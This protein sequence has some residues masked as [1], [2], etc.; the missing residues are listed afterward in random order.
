MLNRTSGMSLERSSR[1][2]GVVRS[3]S[4]N[5]RP[6]VV[7]NAVT[8]AEGDAIQPD[9]QPAAPAVAT[10]EELKEFE[11]WRRLA[12]AR[13]SWWWGHEAIHPSLDKIF[14]TGLVAAAATPAVLLLPT[15]APLV[16]VESAFSYFD[17]AVDDWPLWTLRASIALAAHPAITLTCATSCALAFASQRS[18]LNSVGWVENSSA[19]VKEATRIG[20]IVGLT[21]ALVSPL[22][23]LA[24]HHGLTLGWLDGLMPRALAIDYWG[25][26]GGFATFSY[27][28]VLY[29]ASL[30]VTTWCGAR[31]GP[32]CARM[33]YANDGGESFRA[34]LKYAGGALALVTILSLYMHRQWEFSF[35]QQ[36]EV[37]GALND[38]TD[39]AG[40]DREPWLNEKHRAWEF[41]VAA[42]SKVPGVSAVVSSHGSS[43][44]S[45]MAERPEGEFVPSASFS[46]KRS[47]YVYK[48]GPQGT[49]YY[50]DCYAPP[51]QTRIRNESA[52]A[53][54]KA[55]E[56]ID[57]LVQSALRASRRSA[58]LS[59][60]LRQLRV[61]QECEYGPWKHRVKKGQP[62]GHGR[63]LEQLRKDEHA[64]YDGYKL[65][66]R[67][68][69]E[70]SME[71]ASDRERARELAAIKTRL[72]GLRQPEAGL[73]RK[74]LKVLN[75]AL[76][77]VAEALQGSVVS[78]LQEE[79][80]MM[81]RVARRHNHGLKACE[82]ANEQRH[83][84]RGGV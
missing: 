26:G 64:A 55:A 66:L 24:V 81:R 28:F 67:N 65:K 57:E 56:R 63:S 82:E 20:V 48:A 71:L 3:S 47:G 15:W 11:T 54:V 33:L 72:E 77:A 40:G 49:G 59:V 27:V 18:V 78:P 73:S 35:L 58:E 44:G 1:A 68:E 62:D 37:P 14:A 84:L 29:F 43:H 16:F 41:D 74:Q 45:A 30:P 4:T 46:G 53:K 79:T 6:V 2:S 25:A 9:V 23:V 75:G 13:P 32:G 61:V 21:S 80:V 22:A 10:A 70:R 83:R 52:E 39:E 7:A 19:L 42:L 50:R 5:G 17:G 8:P 69:L 76:L 31:I 51:T 36:M 38:P 12:K 34:L 60:Q